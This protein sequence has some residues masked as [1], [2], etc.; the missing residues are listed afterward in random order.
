MEILIADDDPITRKF[1]TIMVKTSGHEA[2][3]AEN[4][5]EAWDILRTKKTRILISDWMMP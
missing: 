5:M 2:L 3:A 1:L 4:G